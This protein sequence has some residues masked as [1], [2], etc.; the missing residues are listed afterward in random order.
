MIKELNKYN[1]Q[2]KILKKKK[3]RRYKK[4]MKKGDD[5]R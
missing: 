3:N 4:Y 1:G 5:R 2:V